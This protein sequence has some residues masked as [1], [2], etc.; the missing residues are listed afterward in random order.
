MYSAK[1]ILHHLHLQIP[2][3]HAVTLT[4]YMGLQW[5]AWLKKIRGLRA[6]ALDLFTPAEDMAYVKKNNNGVII[7]IGLQSEMVLEPRLWRRGSKGEVWTGKSDIAGTRGQ[8][9]N[10][11]S[12]NWYATFHWSGCFISAGVWVFSLLTCYTLELKC[13][14]Y[15]R[16]W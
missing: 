10:M 13:Y 16:T 15:Q 6:L 11:F 14:K 5:C 8:R 12:N 4:E 2:S 9:L 1:C 7:V 3:W